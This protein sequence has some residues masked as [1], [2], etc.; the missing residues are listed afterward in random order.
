MA[1]DRHQVCEEEPLPVVGPV[2]VVLAAKLSV[3]WV[4]VIVRADVD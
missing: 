1:T 2:I 3:P 4:T